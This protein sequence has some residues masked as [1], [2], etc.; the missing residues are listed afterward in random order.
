MPGTCSG[1][2][3]QGTLSI[4]RADIGRSP[5]G[6]RLVPIDVRRVNVVHH[7]VKQRRHGSSRTP[8]ASRRANAVSSSNSP[9]QETRSRTEGC[10]PTILSTTSNQSSE[11]DW[12]SIS[13]YRDHRTMLF[14]YSRAGSR[15]GRYRRSI[16]RPRCVAGMK[17]R[18]WVAHPDFA[19]PV[20]SSLIPSS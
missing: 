4:Q 8:I 19:G 6:R 16:G 3:L 7:Q 20:L 10:S 12:S 9:I 1:I 11:A 17:S 5:T 18:A 13:T 14:P 15:N 2:Q